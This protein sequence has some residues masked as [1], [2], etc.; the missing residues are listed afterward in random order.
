MCSNFICQYQDWFSGTYHPILL[1][2]WND[3]TFWSRILVLMPHLHWYQVGSWDVVS[4]AD[5]V[6][7]TI[8]T[9]RLQQWWRLNFGR[10]KGD[11]A[12]IYNG[13]DGS[14]HLVMLSADS[15]LENSRP[16]KQGGTSTWDGA[17]YQNYS[18]HVCLSGH[19]FPGERTIICIGNFERMLAWWSEPVA[20]GGHTVYNQYVIWFT[21]MWLAWYY[22]VWISLSLTYIFH[23]SLILLEVTVFIMT[24]DKLCLK[25]SYI[26]SDSILLA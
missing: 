20:V 18:I 17:F 26:C 2:I 16:K 19:W 21:V 10:C 9:R 3:D 8:Q 22:G 12:A 6:I 5:H 14:K 4:V 11:V 25:R 1:R 24:P 15:S 13:L 7:E 23:W